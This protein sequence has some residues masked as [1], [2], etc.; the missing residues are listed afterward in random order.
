M[1]TSHIVIYNISEKDNLSLTQS[2][3]LKNII[4][5]KTELS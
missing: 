2:S 4:L 5:R 3:Q 1:L